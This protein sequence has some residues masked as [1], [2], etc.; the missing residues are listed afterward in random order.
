[1]SDAPHHSKRL[2]RDFYSQ[3]LR[4]AGWLFLPEGLDRPP[5]VVMAHGLAGQRD[6]RLPAFAEVFASKGI[7]SFVFDY[8][9]FGDS[10]GEPR[11]LVSPHRHLADWLAAVNHARALPE[12]DG[13][14]LALWGSSFSGGHVLVTA[15]RVHGLRAAVAQVPFVDGATV[16]RSFPPR[17]IAQ[18]SAHA[19]CDLALAAVGMGPHYVPV[20]ADP[21]EFAAM[22]TPGSKEG[23]LAL[24]PEGSDWRNEMPARAMLTLL[25]YR[26]VGYAPRIM[27]PTLVVCADKDSLVRASDVERAARRIP[28]VELVRLP[29]DHF[30]VYT[31][32][33]FEKVSAL[34]ADFLRRHLE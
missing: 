10:E 6:F 19:A 20:V 8:R 24:V 4:C 11:N 3:G 14:R 13:S 2:D 1:M 9:N 28:E 7:A 34:E 18:A 21:G 5:L 16:G 31:G 25:A 29:V 33:W 15:S 30:D 23:Y 22:N 27:C 32:E 17:F 12:V 26:P